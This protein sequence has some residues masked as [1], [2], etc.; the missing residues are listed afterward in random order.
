MRLVQILLPLADNNGDAFPE[1]VLR[2]FQQ[3]LVDRFGGL[4]AYE[5]SPAKGVWRQD[6]RHRKD[7]VVVV[8]VMTDD[9]DDDWWRRFR[10]RVEQKLKQ[11]KLIV[12]AIPFEE[13]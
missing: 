13:L 11:E 9:P 1:P 3:E 8:E 7:E 2:G 6:G 4:T 12:R 5:R 10:G